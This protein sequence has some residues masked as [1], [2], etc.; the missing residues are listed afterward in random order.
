MI[1]VLEFVFASFWRFAGAAFL[2]AMVSTS[3]AS[4]L[5]TIIDGLRGR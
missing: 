3:V 1:E 2:L 5:A 4:I